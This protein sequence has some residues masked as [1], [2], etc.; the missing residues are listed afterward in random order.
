M[1]FPTLGGAQL[2]ADRRWRSGWRVQENVLTGHARLL[3]PS[4]GRHHSGKLDACVEKLAELA[5]P[6]E[7]E[8]LVV[9]LHGLGR[10]RRSM[11][12]MVKSLE[13]AGLTDVSLRPLTFGI[14]GLY[15]G[16]KG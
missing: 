13:E 9:A 2:W 7:A 16:T 10:S 8:H 3:D 11:R 14:C 1:A 6:T 5:P 12:P 15:V 4:D